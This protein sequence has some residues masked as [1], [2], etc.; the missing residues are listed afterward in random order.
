MN[1]AGVKNKVTEDSEL[2][3]SLKYTSVTKII[4]LL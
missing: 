3:D 1:I 4:S 2:N